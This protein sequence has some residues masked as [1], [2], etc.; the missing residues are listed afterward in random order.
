MRRTGQYVA[1]TRDEGNAVDGSFSATCLKIE[2]HLRSPDP[3]VVFDFQLMIGCRLHSGLDRMTTFNVDLPVSQSFKTVIVNREH[4]VGLEKKALYIEKVN[5]LIEPGDQE[6]FVRLCF[7]Q[8]LS[9]ALDPDRLRVREDEGQRVSRLLEK[10]G[11]TLSKHPDSEVS[12]MIHK[13][14]SACHPLSRKK[15][16]LVAKLCRKHMSDGL[17]HFD[18]FDKLRINSGRNPKI[19]RLVK[20]RFLGCR[21]EMTL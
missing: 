8:E 21:L 12:R 18:P 20:T 6:L 16:L 19:P 11:Q 7:Q 9:G 10:P 4:V 17:C 14:E 1:V 3:L 2:N 5:E 13:F 15:P